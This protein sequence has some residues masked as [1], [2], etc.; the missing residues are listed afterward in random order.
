ML[1]IVGVCIGENLAMQY[2][3][4]TSG[5]VCIVRLY[6]DNFH[7]FLEDKLEKKLSHTK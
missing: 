3:L 7:L 1:F 2:V 4:Y 6:Q 5:N